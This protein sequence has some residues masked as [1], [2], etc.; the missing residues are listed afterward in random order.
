M[1]APVV[2]TVSFGADDLSQTGRFETSGHPSQCGPGAAELRAGLTFSKAAARRVRKPE[3]AS[4]NRVRIAGTDSGAFTNLVTVPA[5]Q[6]LVIEHVSVNVGVSDGRNE[7]H[8]DFLDARVVSASRLF[9]PLGDPPRSSSGPSHKRYSPW[10]KS[11]GVTCVRSSDGNWRR[12]VRRRS[13]WL[14]TEV[15]ASVSARRTRTGP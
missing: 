5:G 10:S 9:L 13:A 14:A 12:P 6:P 11:V 8:D 2:L 4:V 3:G 15:R 7:R 1:S